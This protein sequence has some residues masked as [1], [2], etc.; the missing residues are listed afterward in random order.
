MGLIHRCQMQVRG[1]RQLLPAY[2]GT[3]KHL[4]EK[5]LALAGRQSKSCFF[6]RIPRRN[7]HENV[8]LC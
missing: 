8:N 7:E 5:A 2:S 3:T 4:S 6:G 1:A